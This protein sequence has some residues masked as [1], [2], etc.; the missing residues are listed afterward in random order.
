MPFAATA[1]AR[2]PS[3]V[4]GHYYLSLGDSLAF[5]LQRAKFIAM[6]DTDTYTPTG[7]TTGYTDDL[8]GLIRAR[9]RPDLQVV[10]Y[11]CPASSTSDIISDDPDACFFHSIG[12]ALHD[13]F[14]GSQLGAAVSFLHAHPGQVS[15]ITI[16]LGAQDFGDAVD[17]CSADVSCVAHSGVFATLRANTTTILGQLRAAAPTADIV[18]VIPHNVTIVDFPN[19]NPLWAAYDL[20]MR[21]LAVANHVHVADAFASIT[22]TGR[23]CSLTPM[24]SSGDQHPTD[25]GYALIAQQIFHAADYDRR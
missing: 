20:E 15:P 8:A 25:A 4:P 1:T 10:N 14:T 6:L 12:L 17:A 19:D 11:S 13:E 24:C 23:T 22:L 21:T 3:T 7:F 2:T 9:L 5:G 16:D 18:L